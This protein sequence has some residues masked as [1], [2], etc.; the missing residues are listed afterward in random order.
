MRRLRSRSEFQRGCEK[1]TRLLDTVR[2][3]EIANAIAVAGLWA[4]TSVAISVAGPVD[5]LLPMLS[6][7]VIYAAVEAFRLSRGTPLAFSDTWRMATQ[8]ATAAL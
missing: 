4:A 1:E 5:L 2:R 8:R 6:S 7:L 3:Q